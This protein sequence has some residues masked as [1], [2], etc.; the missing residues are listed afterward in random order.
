[1]ECMPNVLYNTHRC[2]SPKCSET[3]VPHQIRPHLHFLKH[4]I[5][6]DLPEPRHHPSPGPIQRNNL[7]SK[8]DEKKANPKKPIWIPQHIFNPGLHDPI[9]L[10]LLEFSAMTVQLFLHCLIVDLI[11]FFENVR[12]Q[13]IRMRT[14]YIRLPFFSSM[15]L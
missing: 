2:R 5:N 10:S 15:C 9:T 1:M 7:L 4:Y 11:S 13:L 12:G 8:A 3:A 6:I 14:C